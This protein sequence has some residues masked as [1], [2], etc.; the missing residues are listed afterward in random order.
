M[1]SAAATE[2]APWVPGELDALKRKARSISFDEI[3]PLIKLT[4]DEYVKH[5]AWRFWPCDRSRKEM[6]EWMKQRQADNRRK[7][8][9]DERDLRWSL[10]VAEQR[11]NF[12]RRKL[13]KGATMLPKL[14]ESA[15][16]SPAFWPPG[17][18]GP[19]PSDIKKGQAHR[20]R[21]AVHKVVARMERR[22]EIKT[23][24]EHGVRQVD[25]D[26]VTRPAKRQ[27]RVTFSFTRDGYTPKT[28]KA[29]QPQAV[30]PDFEKRGRGSFAREKPSASLP[31]PTPSPPA[32]SPATKERRSLHYERG[33]RVVLSPTT[34]TAA[35]GR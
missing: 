19:W 17:G 16:H 18:G 7:R 21:T 8:K 15:R 13:A 10:S 6:R 32:R 4:F 25:L 26:V 31:T 22:G 5:R 24:I 12:V 33:G 20:L 9:Q 14:Y 28:A 30:N 11:D 27:K 3:G 29:H 23:W 1:S 2:A 34:T 35:R